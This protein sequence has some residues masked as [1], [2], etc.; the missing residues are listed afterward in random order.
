M[1]IMGGRVLVE[2]ECTCRALFLSCR[3]EEYQR[4]P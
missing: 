1:N 3:R 4:A 2:I